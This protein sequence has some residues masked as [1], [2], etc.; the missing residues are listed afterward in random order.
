MMFWCIPVDA[1]LGGGGCHE[2]NR[3]DVESVKIVSLGRFGWDPWETAGQMAWE[4][5]LACRVGRPV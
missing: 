2:E 4:V 1:R 5:V 3:P